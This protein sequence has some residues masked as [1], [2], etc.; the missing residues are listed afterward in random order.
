MKA[1]SNPS[2]IGNFVAEIVLLTTGPTYVMT[3]VY[4]LFP[5]IAALY[6]SK[7]LLVRTSVYYFCFLFFAIS[8][9]VIQSVG[10]S[11]VRGYLL[12]HYNG[13]EV[14]TKLVIA[15]FSLQLAFMMVFALLSL[16]LYSRVQ[17]I[18]EERGDCVF[19]PKYTD[20]RNSP[21]LRGLCLMMIVCFI[22]V[23]IRVIVRLSGMAQGM[24]GTIM[25]HEGYQIGLE[26]LPVFIGCVALSIVHP[27]H[28]LGDT[29]ISI[30][31]KDKQVDDEEYHLSP[32]AS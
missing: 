17:T 8:S 15:G 18:K 26:A 30:W 11:F 29:H 10:S 19:D 16:E 21:K 2:S 13:T 3:A 9:I 14:G 32:T 23:L 31:N 24:G 12:A 1:S 22:C 27:G 4:Q 25:T 5:P 6:G 28:V 7:F 20:K